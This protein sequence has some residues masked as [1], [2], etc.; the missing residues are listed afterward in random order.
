MCTCPDHFVCVFREYSFASPLVQKTITFWFF[1]SLASVPI[2]QQFDFYD[3]ITGGENLL[4]YSNFVAFWF[5][6]GSRKAAKLSLMY[7]LFPGANRKMLPSATR[8]VEGE[9]VL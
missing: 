4:E 6:P 1:L 3:A 9:N 5:K 8:S 2:L 7:H